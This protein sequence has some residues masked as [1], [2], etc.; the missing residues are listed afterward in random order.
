[1]TTKLDKPVVRELALEHEG[2][3]IILDLLPA[4]NRVDLPALE[5]LEFRL[6]GTRSAKH[7]KRVTVRE[8]LRM[9]GW[10]IKVRIPKAAAASAKSLRDDG[11]AALESPELQDL[12][13]RIKAAGETS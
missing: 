9:L 3:R 6:K 1:M 12:E 2:R 10:E 13:R 8:I 7:V 11:Q 4:A 5:M